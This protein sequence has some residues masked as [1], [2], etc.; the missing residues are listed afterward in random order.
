MTYKIC[1][2][3]GAGFIG[4]NL[5]VVLDNLSTGKKENIKHF[6]DASDAVIPKFI[7]RALQGKSLPIYGDGEQTRDF[8]YVEDAV[9]AN[10]LAMQKT[11]SNGKTLN[12]ASGER[13]SINELAKKIIKIT[14]SKSNLVFGGLVRVKKD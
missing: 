13:I 11:R 1:V 4:S 10:I 3:G 7:V 8:T 5:V 12:V 9:N 6:F 2:K 14:N